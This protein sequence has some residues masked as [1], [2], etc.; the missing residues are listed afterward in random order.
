[1][2]SGRT[3]RTVGLAPTDAV[4]LVVDL[5]GT[6]IRS[7]LLVESA[8]AH[9]G[10]SPLLVFALFAALVK[11][12]AALKAIIASQT[13]IDAAILPYDE[14]VLEIVRDARASKRSVYLASA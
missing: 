3:F 2:V 7:D 9:V 10:A 8:F 1:M 6:L 13:E 4:P 12:R 5:D 11:G 14:R